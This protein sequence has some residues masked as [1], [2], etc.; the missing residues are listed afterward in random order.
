[1]ERAHIELAGLLV[2]PVANLTA[3]GSRL[4]PAIA[5][6]LGNLRKGESATG[7]LDGALDGMAAAGAR[8]AAAWTPHGLAEMMVTLACRP[9]SS[10]LDPAAGEGELLIW[11]AGC[12]GIDAPRFGSDVDAVAWRVART[13]LLLRGLGADLQLANSLAADP[14]ADRRVDAVL[15]DPPLYGDAPPILDWVQYAMEHV[16]AAGRAVVAMPARAGPRSALADAL[17]RRQVEAVVLLSASAR[18]DAR[19]PLAVVLLG[20]PPER[21]ERVLVL[22]V[23]RSSRSVWTRQA[24][25]STVSF[26]HGDRLPVRWI[27]AVIHDFRAGVTEFESGPRRP[28]SATGSAPTVRIMSAARAAVELLDSD[29]SASHR[30]SRATQLAERLAGELNDDRDPDSVELRRALEAYLRETDSS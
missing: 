15:I 10:V 3:P 25:A 16:A 14:F 20:A 22:D 12:A 26:R 17:K 1:L 7:M 27:E 6:I 19:G 13:R 23:R 21:F 9:G 8:D 5:A 4:L 28:D 24:L 18:S 11:A 29:P 2:D 30:P